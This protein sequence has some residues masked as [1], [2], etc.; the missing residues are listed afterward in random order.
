MNRFLI[1]L[2]VISMTSTICPTANGT[3]NILPKSNNV[4]MTNGFFGPGEWADALQIE[5]GAGAALY[6]KQD[7]ANIF[8]GINTGEKAHTGLDL[9]LAARE[10]LQTLLHVSSALGEASYNDGIWSD[11]QWEQNYRWVSNKIGQ[12][13]D[14]E[15]ERSTE[16]EGFE[17]Q[18]DKRM[19]HSEVIYLALRFKRPEREIPSAE[20]R[21]AFQNWIQLRIDW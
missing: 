7:A 1:C 4:V 8:L 18:I 19:I 21:E 9:Y 3:E 5:L 16:P 15:G 17:F 2:T 14:G 20:E 12:W 6:A 11:W 13:Y 10:E